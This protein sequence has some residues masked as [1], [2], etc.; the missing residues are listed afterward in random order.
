VAA[1]A[2][3]A[4]EV[5]ASATACGTA[6][7]LPAVLEAAAPAIPLPPNSLSARMQTDPVTITTAT[8]KT[9]PEIPAVATDFKL[10]VWPKVNAMNGTMIGSCDPKKFFMSRSRLPKT[11]PARI[12]AITDN[13][14]SHG[15][16]A[17]PA[18]TKIS[19]V[20]NGPVSMLWTT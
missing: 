20:R 15:I 2:I 7:E 6:A 11:D 4:Y 9:T 3:G 8:P 10:I 16:T 1:A 14:V 19:M 18:P 12:G 5:S 13:I 17:N